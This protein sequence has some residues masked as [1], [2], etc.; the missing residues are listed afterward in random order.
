MI[1]TAAAVGLFALLGV[2]HFVADFLYQPPYQWKNKG[3]LGHPGGLIHAGQ[4]AL[5]TCVILMFFTVPPVAWLL[6][7][8]EFLIHYFTDFTKM[9]VNRIYGWKADTH[10]QFWIALGVD[11]LVH[12]LTYVG[13]VAC[14]IL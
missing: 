5:A 8:A 12:Y 1:T 4:H 3:T 9:N 2:K 10:N 7:I 13:I 14:L 11:Q 6:A